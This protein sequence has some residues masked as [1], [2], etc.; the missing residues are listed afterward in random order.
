MSL[1]L[2]S[3]LFIAEKIKLYTISTDAHASKH[4]LVLDI[5]KHKYSINRSQTNEKGVLGIK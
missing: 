2:S 3:S 4:N 1:F 5:P